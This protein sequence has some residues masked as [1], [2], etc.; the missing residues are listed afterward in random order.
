[1]A[2]RPAAIPPQVGRATGHLWRNLRRVV[3]KIKRKA[4]LRVGSCD[5]TGLDLDR[6]R[7]EGAALGDTIPRIKRLATWNS[8]A[9]FPHQIASLRLLRP[10]PRRP[11]SNQ[12]GPVIRQDPMRSVQHTQPWADDL[13]R[14]MLCPAGIAKGA[15]ASFGRT[16]WER[17]VSV[18]PDLVRRMS[19]V[20]VRQGSVC[21]DS[22][23]I[24][25]LEAR[26]PP[27]GNPRP[28]GLIP[29]NG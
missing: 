18:C 11:H 23:E 25:V 5:L 6:K 14:P 15:K 9:V 1:M 28:C 20:L 7:V 24:P 27:E 13:E 8:A 26:L 19:R 10:M 17:A 21:P 29:R 12:S 2:K 16:L 3:G 4:H 22:L